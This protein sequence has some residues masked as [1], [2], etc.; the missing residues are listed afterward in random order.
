ML[1]ASRVDLIVVGIYMLLMVVVGV[2]LSLF[3]KDDSDF[4]KSGNKMP[5]WLAGFS[6]FMSSFSVWTF[7]GAASGLI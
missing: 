7:T 2:L 3:N 1:L 4:F 6:L 5:W